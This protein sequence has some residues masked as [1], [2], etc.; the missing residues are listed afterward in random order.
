MILALAQVA[1]IQSQPNQSSPNSGV[2]DFA[3]ELKKI[4]RGVEVAPR[5]NVSMWVYRPQDTYAMGFIAYADYMDNCKDS[6]YRYSVL[7]PGITNNKYQTGNRRWMASSLHLSKAER[8][9]AKYLRPLS[10][11]QVMAQVQKKFSSAAYA[12]S[13]AVET[14]TRAVISRIGANSNHMFIAA[15]NSSMQAKAPAPTTTMRLYKE[16]KHMADTNY[17]F[18]DKEFEA[19]LRSA[20]AAAENLGESMKSHNSLYEFVEVYQSGGQ[21]RFRGH[22]GIKTTQLVVHLDQTTGKDFDYSL[23]QLPEHLSGGIAVLSMLD[24]DTYVPGAGYRAGTNLFYIQ[25][26]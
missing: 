3:I 10:A 16:L 12:A 17:V 7:A 21:T 9:A 19:D 8:N 11:A 20:I 6:V 26:V 23:D 1:H 5:D 2:Q 13:S 24:V 22:S 4:M 15:V 25:S 18:L 14:D